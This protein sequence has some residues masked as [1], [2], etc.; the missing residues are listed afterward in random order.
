MYKWYDMIYNILQLA[1]VTV[2]LTYFIN[3]IFNHWV[4]FH[5]TE[6]P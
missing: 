2:Y 1:F 5:F 4:I 3:N 6:L